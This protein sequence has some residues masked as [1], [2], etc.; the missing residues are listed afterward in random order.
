MDA[1]SSIRRALPSLRVSAEPVDRAAYGRDLWPRHHLDV[2]A[3]V[4]PG[5]P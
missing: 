2:R 4:V 3:G 1:F 5:L